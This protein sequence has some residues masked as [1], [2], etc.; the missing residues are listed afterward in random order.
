MT[1]SK[2]PLINTETAKK[3][4]AEHL[5]KELQKLNDKNK[6][7]YE[8]FFDFYEPSLKYEKGNTT[9]HLEGF[10]RDK[11]Y[12]D[13]IDWHGSCE[14]NANLTLKI[15]SG[16]GSAYAGIAICNLLHD[17]GN[18]DTE[19]VGECYSAAS[20][21]LMGGRKR[22]ARTGAGIGIHKSSALVYGKS[23]DMLQE[24][25]QLEITDANILAMYKERVTNAERV[26][27]L[28]NK[29]TF[30]K[31]EEALEI[32]IIDEIKTLDDVKKEK[33]E[34]PI[35]DESKKKA[36]N[37]NEKEI[38]NENEE[39]TV[40]ENEKEIVNENEE[41][42]TNNKEKPVGDDFFLFAV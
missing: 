12:H 24:A 41:E 4:S 38:V 19:A 32:G 1:Q 21:I 29:D 26:E 37:E 18:V 15:N 3:I 10:V 42:P 8:N 11:F 6:K 22:I 9:A 5:S 27:E 7:N 14:E 33:K 40:K 20:I 2:K 34:E 39:E 25:E 28:F 13:I 23:E 16:G 30:I 17:L 36:V 35:K 31:N